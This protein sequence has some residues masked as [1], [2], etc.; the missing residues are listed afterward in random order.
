[1]RVEPPRVGIVFEIIFGGDFDGVPV[2]AV[3]LVEAGVFG[4]DDGVLEVGRDLAEGN[5][6]V[7]LVVG[8]V[9]SPGLQAALDMDGGGGRIDPA[10]D[11]RV[12]AARDQRRSMPMS[13][14]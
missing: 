7:A 10:E 5:E 4:G 14:R 1:M 11:A 12:S 6:F 9:M 2:E 8:L 13:K 3:V